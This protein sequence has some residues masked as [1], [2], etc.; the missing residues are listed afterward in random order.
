MNMMLHEL[1]VQ[2]K[3]SEQ[4]LLYKKYHSKGY[5]HSET[6]V[7]DDQPGMERT[8]MNTK[9]TQKGRLFLYDLLKE[10]DVLPVL[11]RKE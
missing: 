4:W 8:T 10:Q 9:W 5:T 7:I 3:Q 1:G 2:F 6:F 11:E